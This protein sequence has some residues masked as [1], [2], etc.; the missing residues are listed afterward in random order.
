MTISEVFG[1]S[2]GSYSQWLKQSPSHC[3]GFPLG[4]KPIA[5]SSFTQSFILQAADSPAV[6]AAM[7]R[8][9]IVVLTSAFRVNT[10]VVRGGSRYRARYH[11]TDIFSPESYKPN[12][13]NVS[14]HVLRAN[15]NSPLKMRKFIEQQKCLKCLNAAISHKNTE[16]N[17]DKN[18]F[19]HF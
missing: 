11:Y 7:K 12:G 6:V 2:E 16:I 14:F 5:N 3:I 1:R 10:P 9:S 4:E 17:N 15:F 18:N 19:Q 8:H 13:C